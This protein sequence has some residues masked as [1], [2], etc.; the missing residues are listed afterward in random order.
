MKLF[1]NYEKRNTHIVSIYPERAF[2]RDEWL[3]VCMRRRN[4][5][6]IRYGP[7]GLYD[8]LHYQSLLTSLETLKALERTAS[9]EAGSLDR[10]HREYDL[11]LSWNVNMKTK[12]KS[13]TLLTGLTMFKMFFGAGNIVFSLAIGLYAQSMNIWALLGL[14]ITAVIVPF[15][16]VMAMSF[17]NGDNRSFFDRAGKIPGFL[18]IICILAV[19]GPF[20]AMPRCITLS[21]SAFQMLVPQTSLWIFG[22]L[23]CAF[24][25]FCTVKKSRFMQILGYIFAPA[26]LVL[27]AII[28]AK[29]L[30]S[31]PPLQ[32]SD[33][34][35]GQAFTHGL[36][37]GYNTLDL[38]PAFFFSSIVLG[39]LKKNHPEHFEGEGNERKLFKVMLKAS[40]VGAFLLGSIYIGFSFL[41][42]HYSQNL[43]GVKPE[44][45]FNTLA[46][47]VIG[48]LGGAFTCLCV[49]VSCIATTIALT[50]VCSDFLHKE[51]FKERFD[52]R[53]WVVLTLAITY[54][55]CFIGFSGIVSMLAPILQIGYPALIML[56]LMN[57]SHKVFNFGRGTRFAVPA[58]FIGTLLIQNPTLPEKMLRL[59][60]R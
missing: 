13:T 22:L 51:I 44:V 60:V 37:E 30:W 48:P 4:R 16:G 45:L 38:L 47:T 8:Y 33:L 41:A 55:F 10:P 26:L 28:I 24:I 18:F 6:R 53:I 54:A 35:A 50:A 39:L 57:I 12:A 40:G 21:Y 43:V 31:A 56:T 9:N 14:L 46:W 20:G 52:Y 15:T 32:P 29:G 3:R 49:L 58:T 2:I 25:F 1:L 7:M 19:I 23:A 17:Y 5:L 59:F 27:I 42:A 36:K 34:S 11:N